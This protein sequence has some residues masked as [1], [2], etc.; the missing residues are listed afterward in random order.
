MGQKSGGKRPIL[1]RITRQS[2][3]EHRSSWELHDE[4]SIIKGE[5]IPHEDSTDTTRFHLHNRRQPGANAHSWDPYELSLEHQLRKVSLYDNRFVFSESIYNSIDPF[6]ASDLF[7][8]YIC[9]R[10]GN[11]ICVQ[12]PDENLG[13]AMIYLKN[14]KL[15][16]TQQYHF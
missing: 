1:K 16:K 7:P 15:R 9:F 12:T 8:V 5:T 4:D 3:V 14:T 6:C 10:D 13:K 11:I 2:A